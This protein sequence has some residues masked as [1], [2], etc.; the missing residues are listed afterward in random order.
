MRIPAGK[1]LCFAVLWLCAACAWPAV[2]TQGPIQVSYHTGDLEAA[3]RCIHVLTEATGEFEARLPLGEE[4]LRV[5]IAHTT[6]EFMRYARRYSQVN[7]NGIAKSSRGLIVV[8]APRLRGVGDDFAGTLRHELLHV[9]LYRNTDTGALP[10]WL[11][12]GI[13]MSLAN[14][15]YW[16]STL[17][18]AKMFMGGRIIEY[19]NLDRAFLAPGDEMVFNDA[20]AQ[21]LSMTRYLRDRLGEEKFW[22]VVLGC[23]ALPFPDA[24]RQHGGI[25]P[26][27]L[28][29]GYR[30]SLWLIALI[31]TLATGSF[32]TPAAF[33]VVIAYFRTRQKNRKTLRRWALE[34]AAD[35]GPELYTW[36]EIVD[37]PYEWEYD[38]DD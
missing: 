17:A 36:D 22:A 19:R 3:D 24:L 15:Y 38:E 31:G 2:L 25:S 30:R 35:T 27:D 37:G 9:L 11:N 6:D 1:A 16:E 4:P 13:A 28:W 33:L 32:F 23:K 14:E 21:A 5:L 7:V 26:R 20:Y 29:D 34:E 10:R 12:E 18:M 8:K